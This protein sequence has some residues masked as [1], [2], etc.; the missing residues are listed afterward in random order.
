MDYSMKS[1]RGMARL[2]LKCSTVFDKERKTDLVQALAGKILKCSSC[3]L[4]SRLNVYRK[5]VE[6]KTSETMKIVENRKRS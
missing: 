4:N 3:S 6:N 5:K 2:S 1:L